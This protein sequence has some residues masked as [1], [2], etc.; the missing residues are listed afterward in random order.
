MNHKLLG[1]LVLLFFSY[2]V[3]AQG[4][5]KTAFIVDSTKSPTAEQQPAFVAQIDSAKKAPSGELRTTPTIGIGVG[6]FSFYGDLYTKH[7]Q[8]PMVGRMAYD[9]TVSQPLNNSFQMNFY[10]L[11]GK[12]GADERLV[13]DNRNLNFESQIRAGGLNVMYNFDNFLPSKRSASPYISLGIESFEFLSKTDLKDA[14]GNLYNYWSDGSTRSK[15]QNDVNAANSVE[16]HRDYTYESDIRE[17]NLDGFGKYQERS[18]AIPLG[19]GAQFQLN[20]YLSFKMGTTMHFTFTDYIDGVTEKSVGNRKGNSRN[21]NFMFTGV[22]LL[23]N[24]ES[25]ANTKRK[26]SK[27]A[28][29]HYETTDFLALENDDHDKDGVIDFNDLCGGTPIGAVVDE[30][31]CPLDDDIDGIPNYGDDEL[32]SKKGAIVTTRGV[33]LT[34]SL[35]AAWYRMYTDSTGEYGS[36]ENRDLDEVNEGRKQYAVKLGAFKKGLPPE[37]MTKFLSVKD[38]ASAPI[39]EGET[40]YIAG[41]FDTYQEAEARKQQLIKQGF[42]DLGIVYKLNSKYYNASLASAD[43]G[44]GVIEGKFVGEDKKPLANSTIKVVNEKGDV[45]QT[46]KTD[47]FGAFHFTYLPTDQKVMVLLDEKDPQL[48]RLKK[49]FLT[50]NMGANN[51][52]IYPNKAYYNL[53]DN[54]STTIASTNTN[55]NTNPDKNSTTASKTPKGTEVLN[56]PGVVLRI[57]L[58]AYRKPIPKAVFRGVKDLIEIKTDDGLY[59]YM[60]GAYTS[61]DDAAKRKVELTLNGY[62]GAFIAAYKDG[63]RITLQEAGAT[64]APKQKVVEIADNTAVGAANKKLVKFKVQVGV[65]KN[66]PPDNRLEVF[67]KLKDLTG[68]KTKSGLTKYVV[69]SFNNY[70]DAEAFKDSIIKKYGLDDAFVVAL[71]NNEYITI[72]EAL[73][74]LK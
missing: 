2:C 56:T 35:I 17:L 72:P 3:F 73:E 9:L 15:A 31:G 7:F 47:E 19:V 26:V 59:K 22:S 21:D 57:Q 32:K 74:L 67:A 52:E 37:L 62:P 18:F 4:E 20:D 63:K 46:G 51:K 25:K 12:L 42:A 10:V 11:F 23:Y 8:M 38:I 29:E 24:L 50:D 16:L 28:E 58:G 1:S 70:K 69:G 48:K 30:H 55:T 64:I 65:F 40:I 6:A 61:F 39:E 60:S 45:L 66:E 14:N 68:E 44:K 34:D 71:Y 27:E 13:G 53:A 5:K 43:A 41:K 33:E 36:T 49:I 54:S